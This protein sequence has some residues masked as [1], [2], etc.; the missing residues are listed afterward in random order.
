MD[1][2]N[3][4]D[5]HSSADSLA[6]CI[7]VF[8]SGVGG[9]SVLRALRHRLPSAPLLYVADSAHAPYGGRS[10]G[11]IIG[12]SE[13]LVDHLLR[14]DAGLI[15]VACNTATTAAIDALRR[16][17]PGLP[18]VGVEPGIK[19]AV[20]Q[21]RKRRVAV[22]ATSATIHSLRVKH[23]VE[24][25]GGDAHVHLQACPGLADIIESDQLDGPELL[26]ILRP[27]CDRVRAADV[28]TV[29]LGCT[30][31]PFVA[32]QIS[33]LLGPD[34]A[35][36]DTAQAIAERAA[37]LWKPRGADAAFSVRLQT[38]G[39]P[40]TMLRLARQCLGFDGEVERVMVPGTGIEPVRPLSG[41][42]GF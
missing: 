39:S 5:E 12:R 20:T 26:A 24:L 32:A 38:T 3:D 2:T 6:T 15:V 22:M 41:S 29:V 7:G 28:D 40:S 17:W 34:I 42:G 33:N 19:P 36:L 10:R 23:L 18:F 21:S 25:H 35:L 1:S 11:D 14:H 27:Y 37:A 4:F 13:A 9:L 30:H 31:Y 8:D 16:R